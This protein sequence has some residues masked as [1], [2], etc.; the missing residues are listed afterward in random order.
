[1]DEQLKTAAKEF[2]E[3]LTI[4]TAQDLRMDFDIQANDLNSVFKLLERFVQSL[5]DKGVLVD[6]RDYLALKEASQKM[7]GLLTNIRS[8]ADLSDF[9]IEWIDRVRNET[10]ELTAP[11]ESTLS[12]AGKEVMKP[13]IRGCR[14]CAD[15]DGMC[16]TYPNQYCDPD[17]HKKEMAKQKRQLKAGAGKKV[18]TLQ[19]LSEQDINDKLTELYGNHHTLTRYMSDGFMDCINWLKQFKS[20]PASTISFPDFIATAG[21]LEADQHLIKGVYKGWLEK[22]KEVQDE[23]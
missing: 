16:D 9:Y 10:D 14:D 18:K 4:H 22:L 7:D 2:L 23:G 11:G 13:Y 3:N 17:V 21:I 12:S 8:H 19:D 1:M 6:A 5:I 15:S 20:S